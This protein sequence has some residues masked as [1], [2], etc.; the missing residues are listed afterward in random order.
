MRL[1]PRQFSVSLP[2]L[3]LRIKRFDGIEIS[4]NSRGFPEFSESGE[5]LG[6]ELRDFRI[7]TRVDRCRLIGKFRAQV[8]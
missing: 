2:T 8:L 7:V 5:K 1:N 6:F 4:R 3:D